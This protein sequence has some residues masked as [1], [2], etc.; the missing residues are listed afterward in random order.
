MSLVAYSLFPFV[1]KN[2]FLGRGGRY[3]VFLGINF[4]AQ[5]AHRHIKVILTLVEQQGRIL[6]ACSHW[7]DFGY[8]QV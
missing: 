4:N 7:K 6:E 5:H 3:E 1:S 8:C 2:I